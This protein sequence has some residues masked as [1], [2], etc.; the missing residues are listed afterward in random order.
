MHQSEFPGAGRDRNHVEAVEIT[1]DLKFRIVPL[2]LLQLQQ[3]E[4]IAFEIKKNS[5]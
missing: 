2:V 4:V 5:T 1:I 3:G